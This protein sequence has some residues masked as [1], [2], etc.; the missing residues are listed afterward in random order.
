MST[1]NWF[2]NSAPVARRIRAYFAPVNRAS[3]TPVLFDPGEQGSFSF[4]PPPAPWI[5]L[6]WIQGFTRKSASKI[7]TVNTG[8][9]AAPLDQI[10]ESLSASVSFEFLSWT[11]LTMA[12]ATA[13]QHMN[14][15]APATGA[16]SAAVGAQA[17]PAVAVQSAS[18]ANSIVLSSTAG[19]AAGQAVAVDVDN[20]GQTGYV[21]SPVSGAYI[22]QA[23]TDVDYIRRITFN[24]ALI[25]Q[26]TSTSLTLA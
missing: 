12:L 21:A 9:P 22:R 15:L 19:F 5:D 17:T 14:L 10:R 23:I 6:G 4:P 2:S 3:Q 13:S 7:A 1:T 24:V 11:K 25:S 26:V 16:A 18:T 8:I 20:T